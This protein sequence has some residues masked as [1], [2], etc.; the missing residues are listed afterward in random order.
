MVSHN[1]GERLSSEQRRH[2]ARWNAGVLS[3]VFSLALSGAVSPSIAVADQD[4]PSD[5]EARDRRDSDRSDG[6]TG[7]H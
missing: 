6:G 5:Q 1:T 3:A 4:S 2:I 7:T